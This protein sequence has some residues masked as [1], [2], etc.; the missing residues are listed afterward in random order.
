MTYLGRRWY[1]RVTHS[2]FNIDAS[3]GS[4]IRSASSK[5]WW[6]LG[7]AETGKKRN[8]VAIL[9]FDP[10]DDQQRII[11]V[12][13]MNGCGLSVVQPSP[14]MVVNSLRAAYA[15]MVSAT[16]SSTVDDIQVV[17]VTATAP[18]QQRPVRH[19]RDTPTIRRGRGRSTATSSV[20]TIGSSSRSTSTLSSRRAQAA[21]RK[22]PPSSDF[23]KRFPPAKRG[24]LAAELKVLD[25]VP[26]ALALAPPATTAQPVTR[27][28]TQKDVPMILKDY[29]TFGALG[30]TSLT[31]P[32]PQQPEQQ[33][34]PE[35]VYGGGARTSHSDNQ[36]WAGSNHHHAAPADCLRG[37][38]FE[39]LVE[40]ED[41]AN[42][43]AMEMR[44]AF[45]RQLRR[46]ET[47]ARYDRF[48]R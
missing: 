6:C 47:M 44:H 33:R 29:G 11:E 14:A 36:L 4:C 30:S 41:L 1:C 16:A 31:S 43:Q 28:Q 32:V 2:E 7:F 39:A 27:R 15:T 9:L 25:K 10:T 40:A 21:V 13:I 23:E 18:S 34:T 12:K 45:D 22:E 35:P 37:Y 24:K 26:E 17:P 5:E 8:P 46:A 48:F 3:V 38:L 42:R 19:S 20:A